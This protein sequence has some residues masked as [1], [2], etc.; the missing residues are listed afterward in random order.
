[1]K[2]CAVESRSDDAAFKTSN[3]RHFAHSNPASSASSPQIHYSDMSKILTVFGA[4]GNQ[5]G[6]VI[7]AVL[8]HPELSK[9]YKLRAVTRDPNKGSALKLKERGVEVVQADQDDL[10]SLREAVRG[11]H[12]VFG[13][14]N[15]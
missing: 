4:T 15:C 10:P 5:G 12:A 3:C 7:N 14:T 8:R 2:T 9:V 11:S 1:M 6:S 13:V